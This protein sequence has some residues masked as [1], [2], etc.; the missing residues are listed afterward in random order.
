M[1]LKP[2]TGRKSCLDPIP[3]IFMI[4]KKLK[5]RFFL[6]SSS[7]SSSSFSFFSSPDA[8]PSFLSL[9]IVLR[10]SHHHRLRRSKVTGNESKYFLKIFKKPKI[11]KT[12]KID[13]PKKVDFGPFSTPLYRPI[14]TVF[15]DGAKIV[16]FE[17]SRPQNR[18]KA[19]FCKKTEGGGEKERV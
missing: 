5:Q 11:P 19:L 13:H 2:C 17:G 14:R 10:S 16:I 9:F 8:T 15:R 18:K 3:N 1:F 6:S 7:S 4:F 12:P